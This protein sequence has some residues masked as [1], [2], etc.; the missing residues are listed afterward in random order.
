MVKKEG[1]TD[2]IA[3]MGGFLEAGS[4]E[5]SILAKYAS[6]GKELTVIEIEEA[7][8]RAEKAMQEHASA[9]DFAIAESEFKKAILELKVARKY[10]S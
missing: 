9:E 6:H 10:K 3:L 2:H 1:H 8:K 7:K 5:V 4:K